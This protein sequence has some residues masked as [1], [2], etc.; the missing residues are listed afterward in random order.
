ML[1]EKTKNFHI[2]QN[3]KCIFYENYIKK[4]ENLIKL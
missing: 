4:K 3:H 2:S 1:D